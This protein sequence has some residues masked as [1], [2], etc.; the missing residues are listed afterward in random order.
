MQFRIFPALKRRAIFGVSR[1]D[2][3][4]SGYFSDAMNVPKLTKNAK[5]LSLALAT[6]QAAHIPADKNG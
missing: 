1:W 6:E 5:C 4:A 3:E 2:R